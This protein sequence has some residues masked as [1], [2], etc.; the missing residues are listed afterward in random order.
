[1]MMHRPNAQRVVAVLHFSE[2]HVP[3]T[4]R[5]AKLQATNSLQIVR[6]FALISCYLVE[7]HFTE[8]SFWAGIR[9]IISFCS[10]LEQAG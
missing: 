8:I 4:Q 1:M 9:K 7:E 3:L 10:S 5:H 2:F 6:H